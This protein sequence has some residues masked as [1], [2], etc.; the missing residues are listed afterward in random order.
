MISLQQSRAAN[1]LYQSRQELSSSQIGN[2]IDDPVTWYH[3]HSKGDWPKPEP[4]DAMKF[5]TAI[6]E[7]LELGGPEAFSIVEIPDHVL[8]SQGHKRGKAW[9]NFKESFPEDTFFH[10]AGE[11]VPLLEI[12]ANVQANEMCCRFL[13]SEKKEVELFWKDEASGISSRAKIDVLVDTPCPIIVDWKTSRDISP[14]GF[15][16]ACHSLHYAERMAFYRRGVRDQLGLDP[17]VVAVAIENKGSF[18]V[19]PFQLSNDWIDAADERLTGILDRI[20]NFEIDAE[21]D[22]E[23]I[24]IDAPRY[25]KFDSEYEV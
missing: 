21:L 9:T 15:Q 2:F 6:H 12:W 19:Q 11:I 16:S 5:G 3:V 22:R 25:A 20:A 7:M 23:I 1:E 17:A 14:R 4:T 10:R 18:R 8:S 13:D 24:E